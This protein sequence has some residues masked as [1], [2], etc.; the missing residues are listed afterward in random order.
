[1]DCECWGGGSDIYMEDSR[2]CVQCEGELGFADGEWGRM[3]I[4]LHI[5]DFSEKVKLP[6]NF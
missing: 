1:M 6:L 4:G 3:M 5:I 2:G